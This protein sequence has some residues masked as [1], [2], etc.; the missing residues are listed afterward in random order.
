MS[1][2]DKR[3]SKYTY[4]PL[5][6]CQCMEKSPEGD[7]GKY[8]QWSALDSGRRIAG[9]NM[10]K[11]QFSYFRLPHF[12]VF[13][14][15]Q[16]WSSVYKNKV[17]DFFLIQHRNWTCIQ[18]LTKLFSWVGRADKNHFY[19]S[20]IWASEKLPLLTLKYHRFLFH[21]L[22]PPPNS[23]IL[24][25]RPGDMITLLED[26]NEDWWKVSISFSLRKITC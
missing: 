9:Q 5:H 21:P 25:F 26:S 15:M 1:I 17:K 11:L 4:T 19:Y 3:K 14:T 16:R 13:F 22:Y 6:K 24:H 10:K 8:E 12:R 2:G 20:I 23:F 7:T 18:P